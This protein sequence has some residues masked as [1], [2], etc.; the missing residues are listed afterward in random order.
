LEARAADQLIFSG[1]PERGIPI[2]REILASG[3]L[4]PDDTH[5]AR[6]GLA[7]ALSWNDDLDA[8]LGEYDALL[9]AN[10]GDTEARLGRARVL[11]WQDRLGP[12]KSAYEDVLAKDAGNAEARR[13]L[14]R[15]QSW[16]GM[17][18]DAQDRLGGILR[19]TRRRETASS[20]SPTAQPADRPKTLR[21]H[22]AKH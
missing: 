19:R 11:S 14:A 5:R 6:L 1:Q 9:A 4:S 18:L 10:P 21:A 22:L 13:G 12:S 3:K 20:P 17:Q 16:R 8:S 2:F 15:T 7:L